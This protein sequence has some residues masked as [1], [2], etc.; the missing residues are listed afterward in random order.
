MSKKI[1][2]QRQLGVLVEEQRSLLNQ[3]GDGVWPA[4]EQAKVSKMDDDITSLESQIQLVAK[5]EERSI[6]E[7]K[8]TK[9]ETKEEVNKVELAKRAFK[10]FAKTGSISE[11]FNDVLIRANDNFESRAQGTATAGAGGVFVPTDLKNYVIE[12][13]MAH[14]GIYSIARVFA[15][16]SGNTI[17]IPTND[18]TANKATIVG[19]GASV[20]AATDLAFDSKTFGA[21]K[22]STGVLKV[23]QELLDD[24]QYDI[25]S[26]IMKKL[27][28]RMSRGWSDHVA[29]GNGTT[30]PE[31]IVTALTSLGAAGIGVSLAAGSFTNADALMDLQGSIDAAY[32]NPSCRFVLN[33]ATLNTIR[34]FKTNTGEYIWQYPDFQKGLPGTI[35]GSGYTVCPEI[36]GVA[37]GKMS[38]L[39]GDFSNYEI[40]VVGSPVVKRLV[41]LYAENDQLGFLMLHRMDAKFMLPGTIKALKHP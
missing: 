23:N 10:S 41:E 9:L 16:D 12:S 33:Q 27:G 22:Y 5:A 31:G 32:N 13:L 11:E 25:T 26:F 18:D 34:K 28:I 8:R 15:T 1:V 30:Q 24:S 29:K 6:D 38:V 7:A 21:F 40:R 4:D 3:L 36:D 2:L 35:L 14:G 20:G 39:Y 19:Q 17:A 37:T